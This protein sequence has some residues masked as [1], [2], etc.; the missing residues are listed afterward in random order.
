MIE[1]SV[2]GLSLGFM[3]TFCLVDRLPRQDFAGEHSILVKS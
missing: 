2:M 3:Y 1:S